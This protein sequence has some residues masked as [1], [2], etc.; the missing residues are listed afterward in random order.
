MKRYNFIA[1]LLLL[2]INYSYADLTGDNF[3]NLTNSFCGAPPTLELQNLCD[4][5]ASDSGSAGPDGTGGDNNLGVVAVQSESAK[6]AAISQRDSIETRLNKQKSINFGLF[7]TLKKGAMDRKTTFVE[8]GFDAKNQSLFFGIDH[9]YSDWLVLG[10]ALNFIENKV[11]FNNGAGNTDSSG[12][13]ATVFAAYTVADN[14]SISGYYGRGKINYDN[15]RN[16]VNTGNTKQA[17]S[18]TNAEQTIF[19]INISVDWPRGEWRYGS[20]LKI[21]SVQTEIAA[22]TE[23]S[24]KIAT[25]YLFSYPKQKT[26][27]LTIGFGVNASYN[28]SQSWGVLI[29][30]VQLYYVRETENESRN[31]TTGLAVAPGY[32]FITT[33]DVPDKDFFVNSFTLSS[34][35]ENELQLFSEFSFITGNSYLDAWWLNFG[36][37]KNF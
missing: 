30:G 19:G 14:V 17:S 12:L 32:S 3:N 13:S 10:A 15:N 26:E 8:N 29:P 21:D 34:V 6:N 20:S 36:L 27:S 5:I 23:S 11:I 22:Y 24:S 37:R 7:A 18:S 33:T 2:S 4:E 16:V 35:M 28:L 25:N 1:I 9:L 31:I